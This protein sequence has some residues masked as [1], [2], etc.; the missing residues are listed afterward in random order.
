M[1]QLRDLLS[2][3]GS[4]KG[5]LSNITAPP[6]ILAPKSAI[7]FP[8]IWASCHSL[9]LQ[10]SLEPDPAERALLV[11]KNYLCSLRHLSSE[12]TTKKPLNPFLGEL[13]IGTFKNKDSTDTMLIAEQVSHHPPVTACFIHN[14][15]RGICSSGFVAQETSF[16]LL[17]GVTVR[18]HGYAVVTDKKHDER[19]LMTMPTLRIKGMASGRTYVDL[20]GPC[21]ISSS[22][23]FVSRIQ[24][25]EHGSPLTGGHRRVTAE[26]SDDSE[27]GLGIIYRITGD[28]K[29]KLVIKNHQDRVIDEFY[30]DEVPVS[31]LSVKPVEQQSTWESRRVWNPVFEGIHEGDFDKVLRNKKAI[32]EAQRERRSDEAIRGVEWDRRFFTRYPSDQ[33]ATSLLDRIPDQAVRGFDP[34]R[35]D[36]FWKCREGETMKLLQRLEKPAIEP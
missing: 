3:L 2:Y 24:L 31:H 7:E 34:K 29:N 30:V 21:Y 18:Q 23:G 20:E 19:H 12:D 1:S 28:W 8:S 27:T 26:L 36:G 14:K 17:D 9:F 4:V 10:P 32:E 33:K 25:S 6:F 13:F 35:T 22:G 16:S 5:D 11:L 15:E